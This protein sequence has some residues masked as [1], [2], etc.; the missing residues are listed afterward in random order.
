MSE[1]P[2]RFIHGLVC[3]EIRPERSGKLL[4]IGLY[5]DARIGAPIPA[6]VANL[7]F[8]LYWDVRDRHEPS[9][10]FRLSAPDGKRLAEFRIDVPP[11]KGKAKEIATVLGLN[12]VVLSV[13]GE[14]RLAAKWKAG[15][16]RKVFSFSVF[17]NRT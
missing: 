10:E 6:A 3:D 9:G 8:L 13:A 14:Y 15:A 2:P 4:V 5:P 11:P 7:T 16:W 1:R 17:D 12:G